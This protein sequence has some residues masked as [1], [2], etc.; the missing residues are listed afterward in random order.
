MG[1]GEVM[2]SEAAEEE[3]AA[4]LSSRNENPV[5]GMRGDVGGKGRNGKRDTGGGHGKVLGQERRRRGRTNKDGQCKRRPDV[6]RVRDFR[7]N[8]S[9]RRQQGSGRG[10][11][12]SPG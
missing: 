4:I 8:N 5:P 10:R 6:E 11:G 2:E 9:G 12:E 3:R 7:D 1:G